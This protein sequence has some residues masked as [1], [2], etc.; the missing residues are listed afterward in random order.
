M[1]QLTNASERVHG[2][3]VSLAGFAALIRGPSGAGKSDLALRCLATAPLAHIAHRVELV[4]DDQVQLTRET[5]GSLTASCPPAI[6]GK[7]EVRGVGI[8]RM[9][10]YEQARLT[11][12]VDLSAPE[13]VPRYPLDRQRVDCLGVEVPLIRLAPFETSSAVKLVLALWESAQA[14]T[15]R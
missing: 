13:D 15:A 5:D 9:P 14:L 10:F 1:N 4:A 3:A 8:L 2:T 12:V 11:L 7:I 6:A